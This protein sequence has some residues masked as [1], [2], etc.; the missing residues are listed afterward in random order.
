MSWKKSE[1]TKLKS[2]KNVLDKLLDVEI[3]IVK[4]KL[5]KFT[6]V[7]EGKAILEKRRKDALGKDRHKC[8]SS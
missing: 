2:I 3:E 8:S 6:R 7:L 1:F 5:K 4:D